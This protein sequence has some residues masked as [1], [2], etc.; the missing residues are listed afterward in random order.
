MEFSLTFIIIIITGLVSYTAF[1]NP[2][3]YYKFIFNPVLID[4]NKEYYRFWSYGLLH[5]NWIHLI[6]N[7]VVLY[8]FGTHVEYTFALIFGKI[9]LL[10]YVLLYVF[11]L[12]ASTLFDYYQ[13]RQNYAYNAVG[14]SGAVSSVLFTAI[15]LYPTQMIL[16]YG[17]I[18]IP[19][20][21]GGLLYLFYSYYMARNG[22]D[23]IGHYAHFWGAIFGISFTLFLDY[24]LALVFFQ[25]IIEAIR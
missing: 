4:K 12:A 24:K 16:I 17:I 22:N 11:G 5:A 15:L 2:N 20:V 18:P 9:G 1:Q 3:L 23:N 25:Q 8:S 10:Y 7:L 13:H 21:I 14:A 19:A 6:L